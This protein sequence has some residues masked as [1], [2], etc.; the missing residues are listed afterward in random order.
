MYMYIHRSRRQTSC[1]GDHARGVHEQSRF[2]AVFTY[3]VVT[4]SYSTV[5]KLQQYNTVVVVFVGISLGL[6]KGEGSMVL[7]LSRT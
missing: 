6:I 7:Y 4:L 1:Y 2:T 5:P 3:C